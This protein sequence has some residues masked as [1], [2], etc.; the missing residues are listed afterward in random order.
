LAASAALSGGRRPVVRGALARA[1]RTRSALT[2]NP[3]TS[4]PPAQSVGSS[5]IQPL[6]GLP[7]RMLRL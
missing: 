1:G 5:G 7:A 3:T 2:T 6:H 4:R